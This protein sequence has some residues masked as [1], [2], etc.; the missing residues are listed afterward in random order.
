MQKVDFSDFRN[1]SKIYKRRL[2]KNS[3]DILRECAVA[4]SKK[5]S[6]YCPPNKGQRRIEKKFY[7]RPIIYLRDEVK[8]KNKPEDKQQLRKGKLF[9]V[10]IKKNGRLIKS[11]YEKTMRAIKKYTRIRNRGLFRSMFGANLRSI[12]KQIPA[13]IRALLS[14]SKNLLN[15][16]DLNQI[17]ESTK[18]NKQAKIK[19]DNNAYNNQS[20]ADIAVNHGD[21]AAEKKMK[22]LLKEQ[23]KKEVEL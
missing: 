16:K 4:F 23:A 17:K 9:K 20:F 15:L 11:I 6:M 2:H 22:K 19:I 8:K 3:V 1:K 5:A 7:T 12:G 14:K 21:K 10:E 13:N 18:E